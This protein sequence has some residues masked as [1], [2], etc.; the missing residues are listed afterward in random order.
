MKK[1]SAFDETI[2]RDAF[3]NNPTKNLKILK[4][5][6]K[7]ISWGICRYRVKKTWA[8][9]DIDLL[10]QNIMIQLYRALNYWDGKRSAFNYFSKVCMITISHNIKQEKKQRKKVIILTDLSK[11]VI[12]D[13]ERYLP[14]KNPNFEDTLIKQ[15]S[16]LNQ[17]PNYLKSNWKEKIKPD[18]SKFIP[19]LKLLIVQYDP[20][21]TKL[22]KQQLSTIRKE[23]T[24]SAELPIKKEKLFFKKLL[25]YW[26]LFKE[27]E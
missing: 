5:F 15:D 11:G 23:L 4:E 25:K 6:K 1:N 3:K 26:E 8:S 20:V 18:W 2:F 19:S 9:I 21:A 7:L 24:T 13:I 10:T 12:S 27:S 14:N 22:T 16:D 17:F